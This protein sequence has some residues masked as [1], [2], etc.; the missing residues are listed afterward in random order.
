MQ[1]IIIICKIKKII[2]IGFCHCK[3]CN[4]ANQSLDFNENKAPSWVTNTKKKNKK[5]KKK[6][7]KFK[8]IKA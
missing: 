8:L 3:L 4:L 1:K 6:E 7:S 2:D 5:K